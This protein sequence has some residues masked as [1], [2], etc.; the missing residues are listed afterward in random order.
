ME[1]FDYDFSIAK[2]EGSVSK[3]R[4]IERK[5]NLK[6]SGY[7]KLPKEGLDSSLISR[8]NDEV[9]R[10]NQIHDF[11]VDHL[12]YQT[13][14]GED[15]GASYALKEGKGDCTEYTDL[16]VALCRY[17]EIPARRIS[18]FTLQQDTSSLIYKIFRSSGHSWAEVHF[19]EYGWVPFDPTHSDGSIITNFNNLTSKYIYLVFSESDRGLSWKWWGIG[20]VQV[21][22]DRNV[23]IINSRIIEHQ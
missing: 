12:E 8:S 21:N 18:G 9:H 10:V 2:K 14:F 13:F 22:I 16:M 6:N 15:K 3:L 17:N 20:Q 23:K 4:K 11:V 5:R 19:D 1:L 7:Y